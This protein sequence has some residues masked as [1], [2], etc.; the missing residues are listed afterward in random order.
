[1]A[2]VFLN[3]LANDYL[4]PSSQGCINPLF[5]VDENDL[6]KKDNSIESL[7][8]TSKSSN[9]AK[10]TLTFEDD[11]DN[12]IAVTSV[13]QGIVNKKPKKA[14]VSVADCL[15]CSGC[16]TSTEA[17]L[18]TNT[19]SL[20]S[21]NEAISDCENGQQ[22]CL[23][24]TVSEPSIVDLTRY[25]DNTDG[26]H[27]VYEKLET[28]LTM[29]LN[30]DMVISATKAN[31]VSLLEQKTEF[32]HRYRNSMATSNGLYPAQKSSPVVN[33]DVEPKP[34]V[35]VSSEETRF[36][37]SL[38]S[39]HHIAGRDESSNFH[40]KIPFLVSTCP[41]WVCYVE[42]TAP[43]AIPF[44]SSVKSPMSISG[45]LLKHH[46][47]PSSACERSRR[48]VFHV[49]IMP[50]HDK[51]LEAGRKDLAW[52][53]VMNENDRNIKLVPDVDLVITTA[54]LLQL[55]R[56]SATKSKSDSL[57]Q[58]LSSLSLPC[59]ENTKHSEKERRTF[60]KQSEK[61]RSIFSAFSDD[62][63][64]FLA[65]PTASHSASTSG[66]YA[67]FIFREA[68]KEMF[69]VDLST[70]ALSWMPKSPRNSD[71]KEM[72]LYRN[73]EQGSYKYSLRKESNSF[74]VL[75]FA[76]AYG[77]RNIQAIL[78][79][80]KK[81]GKMG[82]NYDF[83]EVMACPSGCM[84]GGGQIRHDASPADTVLTS[85][86]LGQEDHLITNQ[87]KGRESPGDVR[88][89]MQR[90]ISILQQ[91]NVFD[92]SSSMIIKRVYSEYLSSGDTFNNEAR[93]L[94]HTR[95]HSVPK[96]ELSSG[97]VEGVNPDDTKW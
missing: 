34:S 96:L 59:P 5:T 91:R 17:V 81:S 63:S 20:E 90:N 46:I 16:V 75:R 79:R 12:I 40:T 21:L 49:A 86:F 57:S 70:E 15:A 36:V 71:L 55:L 56:E 35:A 53:Q 47:Y 2:S 50:C 76:Q 14:S 18:I 10:T 52:N 66:A 33:N 72:T 87:E 13:D 37:S 93:R 32:I 26:L 1:M 69:G 11:I 67:D 77:F 3:D 51:K 54:E 41:G 6:D 68:S 97:I 9:R 60:T 38:K 88:K 44:L 95:F 78:Q 61:E 92:A 8:N 28:Y 84:N 82:C 24:F 80:M 4:N 30:A 31:Y 85:N 25:F 62:G 29:E 73:E 58:Y 27:E 7:K 45:V 65:A 83:I 94:F 74:P 89:R 64:P 48:R 23:V 19:F 22:T 39:T 43:F 42:K